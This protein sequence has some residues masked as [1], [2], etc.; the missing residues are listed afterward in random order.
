MKNMP[1]RPATI[2]TW[3]RLAPATLRLGTPSG[4]RGFLAVASRVMNPARSAAETAPKDQ[5]RAR[6]PAGL[7][8]LDDRVDSKHDRTGD[9]PC[10]GDVGTVVEAESLILAQDASGHDGGDEPDRQVDEEDPVP[11][12]SFGQ[13][14]AEQQSQ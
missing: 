2:S 13:D 6:S 11:A 5:G 12:Q 14:A 8:G 3:T 4:I 7:G 9:Q 10:P 1:N